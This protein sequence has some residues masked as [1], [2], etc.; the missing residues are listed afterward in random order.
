MGGL[1]SYRNLLIGKSDDTLARKKA[2]AALVLV[3]AVAAALAFDTLSYR[4]MPDRYVSQFPD[5]RR[6]E[7]NRIWI[8]N[9]RD[10]FVKHPRRGFDIGTNV[11]THHRVDGVPYL[12]W[13]NSIGCFD[14]EYNQDN[15]YIYFA[16]DSFT[17]GYA[18]FEQKFGTL[19]ENT[20]GVRIL[21]CG[22]THTG[23]R[24]QYEKFRDIVSEIGR[25]PK[26]LFV[27]YYWN[28]YVNDYAHPHS[29]VY[30]GWLLDKVAVDG[31]S[32]LVHFTDRELA[33]DMAQFL[34]QTKLAEEPAMTPWGVFGASY[35][36]I[37]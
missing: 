28:D 15:P 16:G 13:G 22:V 1:N 29:T 3:A 11:R 32:R 30:D 7:R 34:R 12:I 26:A 37:R 14:R 18:P 6:R 35:C 8:G 21:K 25:L 5:Y 31:N 36:N 2:T 9:P 24:H 27:F 23:Q 20:T 17:W 10:Y 4:L 33:D 19:I